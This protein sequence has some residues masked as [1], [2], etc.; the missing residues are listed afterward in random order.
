MPLLGGYIADTYL[1]RYTT[2]QYSILFAIVGHVLLIVSSI[3][4]VMDN[5]EGAMGCFAVGLVIFG[6]GVGGFKSNVSPLLAEQ[7]KQT[8]PKVITAKNGERVIQDPAVTV[9]RVFLYFYMMI[10]L[11]SLSGGIGMV[12]IEKYI[13]FWLSFALPTFLF[14][15]CPVILLGCKKFY[16]L[17]PPTGSVT[18]KAFALLKLAS[19]GCW[20]ANPAQTYRNMKRDDFWHKVKPSALGAAAPAWMN[21]IDDVWVDQVARGFNACKV[22]FW[23]PLYWLAYNQMTDNLTSMSAVMQ[24]NGVPNDLINNL[25][26]ITLVIFIPIVDT[27]VYPALRKAHI[28]FTPIKRIVSSFDSKPH[29]IHPS[30]TNSAPRPGASASLPPP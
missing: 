21:G 6:I 25:N 13:G 16:R 29:K 1:G 3:P 4:S 8:R 30:N 28:H 26:P 20:S 10:N 14:F 24:L 11:G 9:S 7:I 22:F 17:N 15:F 2:I 18:S 12:Y 27:F 19:K 5:P 23:L